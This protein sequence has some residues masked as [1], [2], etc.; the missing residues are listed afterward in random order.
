MKINGMSWKVR[1]TM[2]KELNT[3]KCRLLNVRI[4][5]K[6]GSSEDLMKRT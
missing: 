6:I 4:I 5:L 3:Y 1:R 2:A